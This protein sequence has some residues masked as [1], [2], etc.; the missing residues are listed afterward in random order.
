MTQEEEIQDF[1]KA[2][3]RWHERTDDPEKRRKI[4]LMIGEIAIGSDIGR[5]QVEFFRGH[6]RVRGVDLVTLIDDLP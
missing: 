1:I 2:L 3:R 4:S 5:E 6:A